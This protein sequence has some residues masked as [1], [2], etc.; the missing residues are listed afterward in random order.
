MAA[1]DSMKR[2]LDTPYVNFCK[3][4]DKKLY[5]LVSILDRLSNGKAF[6]CCF[7]RSSFQSRSNL[8]LLTSIK[9][10][11]IWEI[12]IS[13]GL[14]LWKRILICGFWGISVPPYR[15][16]RFSSL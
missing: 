4:S 10:F 9:T 16:L 13:G 15:V 7:V 6:Y 5:Y 3:V 14:G 11:D 2:M 8:F 12:V 1:A